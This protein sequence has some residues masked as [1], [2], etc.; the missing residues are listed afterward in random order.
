MRVLKERVRLTMRDRSTSIDRMRSGVGCGLAMMTIIACNR[1]GATKASEA[2]VISD[3]PIGECVVD[4]NYIYGFDDELLRISRSSGVT[5]HLSSDFRAVEPLAT[6]HGRVYW[7]DQ[8]GVHEWRE[9]ASTAK[10]VAKVNVRSGRIDSLVAIDSRVCWSIASSEGSRVDCLDTSTDV[11]ET[12]TELPNGELGIVELVAFDGH[13]Y[14]ARSSLDH[15]TLYDL[16][17]RD[18]VRVAAT[19]R[20]C[21]RPTTTTEGV[22][23]LIEKP[24][25]QPVGDERPRS[26]W[27][28]MHHHD[29]SLPSNVWSVETLGGN[30]YVHQGDDDQ[31]STLDVK[32]EQMTL[33]HF[34]TSPRCGDARALFGRLNKKLVEFQ[35]VK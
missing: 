35:A 7:R 8:D 22:G 10:I 26:F 23:I 20:N 13:L 2:K 16:S 15:C 11:T 27:L 1:G 5:E 21:G 31:I 18:P 25:S 19:P 28:P 4:E 9:G 32:T 30:T 12:W 14:A 24:F 34:P 6:V 3:R 33:V 29:V 17:A